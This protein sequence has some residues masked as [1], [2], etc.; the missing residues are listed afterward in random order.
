SGATVSQVGAQAGPRVDG[1]MNDGSGRVRVPNRADDTGTH[2]ARDELQRTGQFGSE[3]HDLDAMSCGF[4]QASEFVPV[5]R[6]QE[7]RVMN[8]ASRT[9]G[10]IWSCQ[11]VPGHAK[12]KCGTSAPRFFENGEIAAE[13]LI[14]VCDQSR[15]KAGDTR[16]PNRR[17]HSDGLLDSE[18]GI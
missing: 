14:R 15:V 1:R 7:F 16:G 6:P 18:I 2:A 12:L 3:R 10:E 11:V 8:A 4:L 5:R 13:A 9:I 17:Q